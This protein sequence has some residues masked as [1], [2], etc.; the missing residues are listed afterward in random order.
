IL[1]HFSR[2]FLP[3]KWVSKHRMFLLEMNDRI[4]E[5]LIRQEDKEQMLYFSIAHCPTLDKGLFYFYSPSFVLR[6]PYLSSE[7]YFLFYLLGGF[8]FPPL[9]ASIFA[10]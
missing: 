2:T 3:Y 4:S 10:C 6:L 9:I 5:R 8:Q 7:Q 1:L